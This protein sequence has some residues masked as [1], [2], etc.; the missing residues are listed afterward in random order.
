MPSSDS[1]VVD[2]LTHN[3]KIEGSNRAAGKERDKMV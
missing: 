1:S 3:Y 2:H